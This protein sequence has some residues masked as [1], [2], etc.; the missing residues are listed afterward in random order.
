MLRFAMIFL[1]V[2]LCASVF[3]FYGFAGDSM[4][5]AKVLLVIFIAGAIVALFTGRRNT[6]V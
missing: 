6:V 3:G 4:E 2:A 5:M 1:V